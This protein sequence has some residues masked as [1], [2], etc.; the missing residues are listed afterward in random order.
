MDRIRVG[1]ILSSYL[2]GSTSGSE[3]QA[4]GTLKARFGRTLELEFWLPM[5]PTLR[6]TTIESR[7]GPLTLGSTDRG[8]ALLHFDGRAPAYLSRSYDLVLDLIAN[9]EYSVALTQYFASGDIPDIPLDLRGT[10]FQLRCWEYLRAIPKGETRS[11]TELA[12][13]VSTGKAVRAAGQ[14][15]AN[16]PIAIFV[17]C[18]RVIAADGTLGGYG[19]GLPMKAALLSLEGAKFRAPKL[20]QSGTLFPN[21]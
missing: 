20:E 6:C 12:C 21:C 13:A 2:W 19:G 10:P 14:A 3:T 9:Y 1:A 16:N 7:F 8:L 17:P 15:N 11:Y 5:L 18:H 4:A